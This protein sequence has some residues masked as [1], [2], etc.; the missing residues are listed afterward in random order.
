[1]SIDT[2][3]GNLSINEAVCLSNGESKPVEATAGSGGMSID[4]NNA[5]DQLNGNEG[6]STP[7]PAPQPAVTTPAAGPS[8][9]IDLPAVKISQPKAAKKSATIKW[10]K[11]SKKKLKKIKKIEIQYSMDKSFRT[12]VKTKYVKAKKTSLKIKKLKSKKK[13]YVRL[14]AYT[15]AGGA[16]HVSKWSKVKTIKVN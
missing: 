11:V 3:N 14:R 10:K 12:G 5:I 1:M 8:E 6:G 4:A 7:T 9:I 2:E 15:A 13:Y 16:V